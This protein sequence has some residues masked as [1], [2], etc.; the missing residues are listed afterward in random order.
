M[1]KSIHIIANPTAGSANHEYVSAI[2]ER[3]RSSGHT[4]SLEYTPG[5]HTA[6]KLAKA[7]TEDI[8][9]IA[10]GDGT[11]REVINGLV[12]EEKQL[13][14]IPTGTA[15]V[16][17]AEIGLK[18][19]VNMVVS[20]ITAGV[21]R[22]FYIGQ[23]GDT[24]FSAMASIGFDADVVAKVNV[25]LKKRIGRLAYMWAAVLQLVSYHPSQFTV[26]IDGQTYL[27]HWALILNGRYYAGM[28]TCAP[29]ASITEE[30]LHVCLIQIKNRS[31]VLR[32]AV[33]LML[34][35]LDESLQTQIISGKHIHVP[36]SNHMIQADG[37]IIS[38]TPTAIKSAPSGG[39]QIL[40][41]PPP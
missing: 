29:L 26:E 17:A 27:C 11:I 2:V 14:L 36:S 25:S 5:P 4:V 12:G 15:N 35:R 16:L 9:A 1:K 32:F 34:G 19:S 20:T 6:G 41:P 10:G 22:E 7:T 8:I 31:A 21:P 39:L 33:D 28:Y 38:H 23:A 18:K 40:F 13:A 24:Y 37:D 30:N 3:L